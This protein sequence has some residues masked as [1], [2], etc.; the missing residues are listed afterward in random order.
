VDKEKYNNN[1]AK[2]GIRSPPAP[3]PALRLG[4]LLFVYSFNLLYNYYIRGE[5]NA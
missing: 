4:G 5:E 3:L 2:T 1:L